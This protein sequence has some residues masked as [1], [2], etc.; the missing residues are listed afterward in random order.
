M[1]VT[2]AGGGRLLTALRRSRRREGG[3]ASRGAAWTSMA[4]AGA[5]VY[6]TGN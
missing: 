2:L 4:H 5:K 1:A 3:V 6:F